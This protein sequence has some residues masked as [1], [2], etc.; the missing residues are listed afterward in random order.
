LLFLIEHRPAVNPDHYRV[1]S[2]DVVSGDFGELLGPNKRPLGIDMTGTARQQVSSASGEQLYTL[3]VQHGHEASHETRDPSTLPTGAF[4]HVLD[5]RGA[6][7]FCVDLA[8]FGHGPPESA[9]IALGAGGDRLFVA[10]ARAGQL[11]TIETNQLTVDTLAG[12]QPAVGLGA[13]PDEV[14]QDDSLRLRVQDSDLVLQTA[15]G[16]WVYDTVARAWR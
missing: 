2:L 9:A 8:G 12:G 13:L 15:A 16:S 1:V 5:L 11:A 4:V 7:A 10:D 14:A 3:Y 6:W